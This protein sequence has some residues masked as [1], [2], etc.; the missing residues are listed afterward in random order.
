M[1]PASTESLTAYWDRLP[2][3]LKTKLRLGFTGKL[4]L[5]DI[6]G[7]CLRSGSPDL[8]PLAV[9]AMQ[10]AFSENPLDGEMAGEL[11]SHAPIRDLLPPPTRG[12]MESLAGNWQRP[13]DLDDFTALLTTRNMAAL[14]EHVERRI[15]A[16]PDNLFWREQ[17]W[18][19][20]LISASPGW[21]ESMIDFSPPAGLEPVM[22]NLHSRLARFRGQCMDAARLSQMVGDTFGPAYPALASGFCLLDGNDPGS[23]NLL[24]CEAIRHTPWNTSLLLRLHDLLTGVDTAARPLPGSTAILLY[25]W[26]KDVELDATLHSLFVSDMDNAS[27]FVLDNGCTDTTGKV[28]D[29]W[30]T[31]F[32]SHR[33]SG[34]LHVTTLPVNIGAPAARN[35][36]MHMDAVRAHDFICYLDDDIMLPTDWLGRFG[37][38]VHAYPEAGVWGCKVVDHANPA[39]IQSADSHLLPPHD[40]AR[41]D[42]SR[43]APNPFKLS[44]LHIQTLDAGSFDTLRPCASVTGCC[45]LFRT[46]RLLECGD[47]AIQLSPSQYDDM[48]H[49]LRLCEAGLFPVYQGHLTIRHKKRTGTATRLSMQEEGSALGN[50]Y[51]MQTMHEPG[52][53]AAA[54]RKEQD[55]LEQDMLEK[56]RLVD[57][58]LSD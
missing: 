11:L 47:F 2:E 51:K 6:A 49:D 14:R 56:M 50:K 31:R 53:I 4:H 48:E 52:A 27:I 23:A 34:R 12:A 55:L 17:A 9:N 5:L 7:W 42:L 8:L 46:D 19:F 40:D 13:G 16:D 21:A 18:A 22:A 33:G 20:G 24:L 41:M 39:L 30:Q 10:T 58:C 57:E 36:L 38:A 26:N 43:T 54:A 28:L 25:S 3:E 45:H 32:D 37:A 1:S 44:D 29:S 35:W 15:A